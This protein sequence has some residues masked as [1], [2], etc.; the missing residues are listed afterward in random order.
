[1]AGCNDITSQEVEDKT[2]SYVTDSIYLLVWSISKR[3]FSKI[4]EEDDRENPSTIPHYV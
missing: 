3:A 4:F 1:M 2:L